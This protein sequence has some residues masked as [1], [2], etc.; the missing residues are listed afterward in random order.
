MPPCPLCHTTSNTH[1]IVNEIRYLHCVN[2][3][4][5]FKH[6]H[7]FI[8]PEAERERY[9]LHQN[10]VEDKAYQQF[11]S[12]IA[13]AVEEG[14][15]PPAEGLDFGAGTG[16][17]ISKLLSEKGFKM[18]LYDP[19]FYAET[20]PLENAYDFIVCCEVAEHFHYPEKE[21]KLLRKLLRPGGKLY[22]MTELL[23][24]QKTFNRWYYKEDPTHVAF[25]SEESL[26]WIRDNFGFSDLK[27]DGR[28][29]ILST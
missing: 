9:L 12:P 10:D 23:P 18:R 4:L 29:V 6:P 26:Q 1:D 21:F 28:L 15:T 3:G 13:R 5:V 20:T 24:K 16:P 8:S 25:Y 17:V 7:H 2:C 27:I 14:F 11:V 22:C 19:F